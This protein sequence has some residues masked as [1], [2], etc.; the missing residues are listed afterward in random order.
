[1]YHWPSFVDAFQHLPYLEIVRN[2]YPELLS[3]PLSYYWNIF[4]LYLWE[5]FFSPGMTSD[6]AVMMLEHWGVWTC[7]SFTASQSVI[8]YN[9]MMEPTVHSFNT[10]KRLRWSRGSVLALGTQG[11]GFIPGRSRRIFQGEKILSTPS[12]GGEVKPSVPCRRFTACKRS[13]N[14]MWKSG[15]SGKIHRPF[16]AHTVPPL[17][18]RISGET[19]SGE[20]WNI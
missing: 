12:F 3:V 13:L 2:S 6:Q 10:G 8:H 19:A 15:I 1:V 5:T 17:A 18:S 9:W 20:S 4:K 7:V 14:A 11:R 16:F